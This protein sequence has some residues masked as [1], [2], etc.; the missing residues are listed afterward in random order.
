M[1]SWWAICVIMCL[2][3]SAACGF[4]LSITVEEPAGIARF[5]E[6]VSGGI[7]L[8][9]GQ[10][11]KGE[12]FS[13]FEASK[14]IPVQALPLVVDEQ[15][16]LRWVLLDFQTD[17]NP[18]Q[19]KTLTLKAAYSSARPQHPIRVARR[20]KSVTVNTGKVTFSIDADKPFGLFSSVT[21][22][23]KPVVSGGEASC[24]DG[25]DGKRYVADKPTSIE[26]EYEGPMRTTVCVKGRFVGDNKTRLRYIARITAWAGKSEVFVKYKVS[27]SNEAHYCYRAIKDSSIA[28]NLAG[29]PTAAMVGAGKP[30]EVTGDVS[31]T[32]GLQKEYAG[33]GKVLVGR[34]ELW[35]SAGKGDVA[36]GWLTVKGSSTIQVT[37]I[38]FTADP[39]R[40]L[41][42]KKG[43]LVLTGITERFEGVKDEKGRERGVPHAAEDRV[44]P[45]CSHH[46]SRYLIDFNAPSSAETA[47]LNADGARNRLWCLAPP[48]WYFETESLSVGKFG[49]Q[50]N[51]LRC[52]DTW[53]WRYDPKRAPR[54]PGRTYGQF[55]R[56]EDNHYETEEDIVEVLLLMWLRTGSRPFFDNCQAW[57][58]YNL[59]MQVWRTDDW[60]YKDGGVW[61]YNGPYGNRPQR[62]EDPVT[63]RRNS[64]PAPWAKEFSEPLTKA[65]VDDL[66][67]LC[68]AKACYCHNWGEGVAGWFCITGDRDAYEAA[69]DIVEQNYDTQRRAFKRTP[70]ESSKFSRDFT[71]SC[72]LTN[73]TRLIAP[74]DP[75]VVEASEYLARVY[76]QRP[77]KEPRG[78]VNGAQPV[79]MKG[80][81][82]RAPLEKFVGEQGMAEMKR[83]GV[84]ENPSDGLLTKPKSGVQW[85]PIA[86]P[87]I[88]MFPPMSHAMDCY[89]RIT[90]SEDAMDWVIAYGQAVARVLYQRHGNQHPML[91][92]DFP[93]KGIVKDYASWV[94]KPDNK[95]AEGLRVSGYLARFLPDVCARAYSV[96]GEAHL[97]Q[98]AYDYWNAG[99]HRPYQATEMRNLGAVNMWCNYYG[100]HAEEVTFNG[101]TFHIWSHPRKDAD[102]PA[103]V[104]DLKVTIDGGKAA[105]TFTAP[106]D[107]GGGKVARYQVK[108]SDKPLVDYETFLEKYAANQDGTVTN[109]WMATNL[110]A[111]PSPGPA[112]RRERFMVTGVPQGARYFA[113]RSFD[114]SCNR[115]PLG[116]VVEARR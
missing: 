95:G 82:A 3:T 78:L 107:R 21:V 46:S 36:Q 52:Y 64:I 19:K 71:R 89:Y 33:G 88:W 104:A 47:S 42:L 74:T 12:S 61:W 38:L 29:A 17:L 108:C 59:D 24:T 30:L 109:W 5:S 14:E 91:L 94:T 15:G 27:N 76:F 4:E 72:Y 93:L 111:E 50:K 60:R 75:Y 63:G 44:L 53:G 87:N 1:R 62:G 48:E 39:A 58:E 25:F 84:T 6:S 43:S 65:R 31:L 22:D 13:L 51:E 69:I 8:P 28:L 99:S 40:R 37:D 67:F 68:R 97:K 45:D 102:P 90:G 55:I 106:A 83:L 100:P 79:T 98:R 92:A 49:T 41:A 2:C 10:F 110:K 113:V 11:K 115:S 7:P 56:G 57:A 114:D 81:G 96:C 66:Y 86:K 32:Q 105:V 103:A 9:A 77:V 112:G 35:S 85:Y 23:G 34:K 26:V 116:S 18:K 16:Y 70:G 101:R 54:G 80:F 20:G 73:A